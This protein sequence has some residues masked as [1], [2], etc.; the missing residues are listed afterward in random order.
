MR[1]LAPEVVQSSVMDCGPAALKCLLEGFGIPV[2]YGRLRE[3]CQTDVDGT[4]IDALE[5]VAVALGLDA[6]Q[7]MLPPDHLFIPQAKA[8]PAL[9]VVQHPDGNTHFVIV[10]RRH[11]RWL[12]VMDPGAGRRWVTRQQ[13]LNELY[14]HVFAVDAEAY[15]TW[16]ASDEALAVLRVQLGRLGLA[17]T[18]SEQQIGTAL[19]TRAWHGL[20]R[21]DAATRMVSALIEARALRRGTEAAR[22][23]QTLLTG[24]AK[25]IPDAYWTVRP[26]EDSDGAELWL[27]GA[28]LLRIRGRGADAAPA[29]L[30][31]ELRAAVS[32]PKTGPYRAIVDALAGGSRAARVVLSIAVTLLAAGLVLEALLLRALL[33]IDD[34]L[35]LTDQRL[36]L[37]AAVAVFAGA[38]LTLEFLVADTAWRLGRRLELRLR[39]AFLH[40]IPRLH[41]RYLQSRLSSDMAERSHSAHLLRLLPTLVTQGLRALVLMV[42]T[43][44][45]IIWLDPASALLALLLL[46][47]IVALPL[48]AQPVL[49]ERELRVRTHAGGLARFYLDALVGLVAVRA[50]GAEPTIARQ[51]EGRIAQWGHAA[52]AL[53]RAA[54]WT[55]GL[56][57]LCGLLL[58]AYLLH[59]HIG[60]AGELSAVL[61]LA[62]WA[63]Q[64]P[65][66]GQELA[67]LMRQL[68]VQRNVA[69]RLFEPLGAPE[70]P[71]RPPAPV[72]PPAVS[73]SAGSTAV[74]ITFADVG[75]RV[76]GHTVLEECSLTVARGEHIAIVGPSGAGKSTLVGLLLGWYRPVQGEVYVDGEPLTADMLARLRA[77]TAWVD[78]AVQLWNHAF[79]AN[80]CYGLA[81]EDEIDLTAL[82]AKS[83]LQDVLARLPEGLQTLLGEGGAMVS[84]GEGQ[85]LRLAR[86]LARRDMQLAIL[87]EPFR[88]LD[89]ERRQ[90]LLA[91]VRKHWHGVTLLCVTHDVADTQDFPRVLVIE[92]GRI[93]E[94][95][96]P[97]A[98]LARADSRYRALL[99]ADER[100]R[101]GTWQGEIW[102]RLSL[103]DGRLHV[104]RRYADRKV[105]GIDEG[106][107][108]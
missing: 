8:W 6:E 55:E 22:A 37:L 39:I 64:L 12:Q 50:H 98:L 58:A 24:P 65:P 72:S 90:T 85:R 66:L 44:T 31:A 89:R 74:A 104:G 82:M 103:I 96:A 106:R 102:R 83:A 47:G 92:Q 36:S 17:N 100:V 32:E 84:G 60:R 67:M 88:G 80:V 71:I 108:G 94:D 20:A 35:V 49:S 61:L 46:L 62:Y 25:V 27:T 11:G 69:L 95:G 97:Q 33:D 38:L 40:K 59:G 52:L 23:L 21:L 93:I 29:A 70:E 101:Y 48:A 19:Q 51:Y 57:L 15:R 73:P 81:P 68:A 16:A 86:A 77:H 4:S 75:V 30:P 87:D 54:V 43:V 10:W 34:T 13:F 14:M 7:V 3:A 76:A 105:V 79:L 78:P 91:A 41:D 45:G 26:K 28:V 2:G 5:A 99:A 53:G 9:I 1:L 42:L 107:H 63:L 18:E 56:S